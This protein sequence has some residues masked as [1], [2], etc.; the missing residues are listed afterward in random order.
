MS[1]YRTTTAQMKALLAELR[2]RVEPEILA[3]ALRLEDLE[4]VLACEDHGELAPIR[5]KCVDPE[6]GPDGKRVQRIVVNH[7]ALDEI[8]RDGDEGVRAAIARARTPA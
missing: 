5:P 4:I 7:A 3:R 2:G 1:G 6:H 8:A